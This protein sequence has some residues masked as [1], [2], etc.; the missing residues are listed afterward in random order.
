MIYNIILPWTKPPLSA[1]DRHHWTAAA[2]ITKEI[3]YTAWALTTKKRIPKTSHCTV[4]LFYKPGRVGRRDADNLMPTMKALCDGIVDAGVV[5]DD[6][7]EMMTKMMPVIK[8]ADKMGP[9]MWLV[10]ETT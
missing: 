1:N 9:G 7:P 2:K 4:T 3:R 10:V 6:I 8:P 5:K